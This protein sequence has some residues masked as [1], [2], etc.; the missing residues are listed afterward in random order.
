MK[1]KQNGVKKILLG[2]AVGAANGLL[3]GGGGM[4]AVPVLE[5]FLPSRAAH[6]TAIALILPCSALSAAV[7]LFAGR[8]PFGIFLPVCIG[9]TA[10]G[11]FGARLLSRLSVRA[12]DLLFGALMLAAGVRM[13]LP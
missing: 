6:A 11:L 12:I 8:I 1:I 4:I 5:R 13:L 2:G 3:G 9:V 7:Y 10:G